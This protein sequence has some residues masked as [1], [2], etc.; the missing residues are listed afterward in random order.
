[1][2]IGVSHYT[3]YVMCTI[4]LEMGVILNKKGLNVA[5]S[6]FYFKQYSAALS[7][8][9]LDQWQFIFYYT[10]L[11]RIS[12][13]HSQT[14]N[15]MAAL[16]AVHLSVRVC[17]ITYPFGSNNRNNI[18]LSMWT[19]CFV[20]SL[21]RCFGSPYSYIWW[22]SLALHNLIWPMFMITSPLCL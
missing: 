20:V 5:I 4:W 15:L 10:F 7:V 8:I 21:M 22:D 6:F 12:W 14:W 19:I 17:T 11:H 1:M 9:R 18:S 3:Y 13:I 2:V 16:G